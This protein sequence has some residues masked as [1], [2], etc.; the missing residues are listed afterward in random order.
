MTQEEKYE[1]IGKLAISLYSKEIKISLSSLKS[2]LKDR[3]VI[4]ESN[5][6][7]AKAV[8]SAYK[9]WNKKDNVIHSA[10]AYTYTD[11][12]GNLPWM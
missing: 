9:Y 8:S 2:I 4:Y 3:N 1:F 6:G 10:I 11:K 7:L 12:N 5:R